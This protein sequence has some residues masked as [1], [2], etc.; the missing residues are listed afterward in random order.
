MENENDLNFNTETEPANNLD[1]FTPI[2][3]G[4]YGALAIEAKVKPTKSG[5]G[6]VLELVFLVIDPNG[7]FDGRRLYAFLNIQNESKKAE[8]IGRG[9]LSALCKA[10][11][12]TGLVANSS[13]LLD[14]ACTV[15]VDIKPD[16]NGKDRNNITA[17]YP[18][19]PS[20]DVVQALPSIN[21][22]KSENTDNE[23][24]PEW[25]K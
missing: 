6:K 23:D 17:F 13:E 2:P 10:I 1:E 24:M 3:A 9:L 21:D 16:L 15:K 5:T 4:K 19:D 7:P 25:A 11:G 8:Q 12:K 14:K 20:I 18:Y 22:Q